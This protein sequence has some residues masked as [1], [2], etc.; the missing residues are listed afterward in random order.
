MSSHAI[1]DAGPSNTPPSVLVFGA[2]SIGCYVGGCLRAAGVPVQFV[3]RPRVLDLLR[4]HGLGLSDLGGARRRIAAADLQLHERVPASARPA[5]VLL[6]VKSGATADAAAQLAATLPPGT[7]VLSL[8]NGVSNADVAQRAAPTLRVLPGMVPFN[9]AEMPEAMFHRGTE[10]V[11]AAQD[12]AALRPWLPHFQRAGLPLHLHADLRGIQWGKLLLNLNN[13]VNALSGLPLRAQLLDR[14]FRRCTAAL[15][16][17]ALAALQAAG[18]A[19][20]R[21]TPLPPRWLPGLLRLPSPVFRVLAARMLRID[22]QARSSMAD[23]LR[24]RRPTEVDALCGEVLR[25]A[26]RH[27]VDAPLNA[28]MIGL[29]SAAD[30]ARLPRDGAALWRALR[31]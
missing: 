17:E 13:P 2:G 6:C 3:G 14:D 30:P 7:T 8:Q 25:L 27:G 5:L 1:H 23:D 29:V 20:A 18:I 10:G 31:G 9:V 28:R 22:A 4:R 26:Q 15:V 12:D 21:V 11:L 19:P 24:L 16:E